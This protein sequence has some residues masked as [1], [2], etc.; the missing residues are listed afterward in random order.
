M[1]RA[2][3]GNAVLDV[4]E[5]DSKP[6]R[7]RHYSCDDRIGAFEILRVVFVVQ[8]HLFRLAEYV[9]M[10]VRALFLAGLV[11][12]NGYAMGLG[13]GVLPDAGDKPRKLPTSRMPVRRYRS[14]R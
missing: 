3:D 2:P 1:Q 7:A 9:G 13:P 4:A 11:L 14:P 8:A 10:Q 12:L 5:P 6:F